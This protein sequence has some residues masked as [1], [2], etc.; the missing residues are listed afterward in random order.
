MPIDPKKIIAGQE[1]VKQKWGELPVPDKCVILL[2][3]HRS[4]STLLCRHLELIGYGDPIEAFHYNPQRLAWDNGWEIDFNDPFAYMQQAL[5]SQMVNGVFAMKMSFNQFQI[6]LDK[7]HVLMADFEQE[8][9]EAELLQV[10]FPNPYTIYLVRLNKV[11]QAVS[12]SR[13]LQNGIWNL[14][15]DHSDEYKKYLMPAVYDREHIEGCYEKSLANDVAWADFLRLHEIEHFPMVYET[16]IADY[17]N[18]LKALHD[19]LDVDKSISIPEPPLKKISTSNS[20]D[21]G[22]RFIAE[23]PWLQDPFYQRAMDSGDFQTAI[24]RRAFILMNEKERQ[25]WNTMPANQH[26]KL[27]KFVFRVKRK[28]KEILK[29]S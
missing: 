1:Y 23:T 9:N 29:I 22:K 24:N 13:A 17:H 11:K 28:L 14:P 26:K 25:R 7:A 21:W 18:Q 3:G 2:M 6:F 15:K 12:Y 16:M 10:F 27:K 20:E 4:G 8:L 5:N 19:Y